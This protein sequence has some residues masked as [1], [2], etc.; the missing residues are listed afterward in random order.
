LLINQP[1]Q[2]YGTL[3]DHCFADTKVT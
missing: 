3:F 2:G 1:A